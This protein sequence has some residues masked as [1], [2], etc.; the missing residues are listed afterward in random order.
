MSTS[1]VP[2]WHIKSCT[3]PSLSTPA[4]AHAY[5]S[6]DIERAFGIPGPTALEDSVDLIANAEA[7]LAA[8]ASMYDQL[9]TSVKQLAQQQE[10]LSR[11]ISN[12]KKYTLS[13][14]IRRLPT[15]ILSLIFSHAC[16]SFEPPDDH[17]TPLSISVTCFK[18]R[19]IAI[20]LPVLWTNIFVGPVHTDYWARERLAFY[21]DRAKNLPI[22]LKWIT[23][24][25]YG[26][27]EDNNN[28]YYGQRYAD[29]ELA[30]EHE[31][32]MTEV[33][34]T[35]ESWRTVDISLHLLDL[36]HLNENEYQ[37][38]HQLPFLEHIRCIPEN[39]DFAL[40]SCAHKL[41]TLCLHDEK[42]CVPYGEYFMSLS[43]LESITF[44]SG[45]AFTLF[46]RGFAKDRPGTMIFN[47]LLLTNTIPTK[48]WLACLVFRPDTFDYTII[49]ILSTLRLPVLEELTLED[50]QDRGHCDQYAQIFTGFQQ[51]SDSLVSLRVLKV[52]CSNMTRSSEDALIDE[53]DDQAQMVWTSFLAS[54][55]NIPTLQSLLIVES[56]TKPSLLVPSFISALSSPTVLPNLTSLELV[57]GQESLPVDPVVKLLELR[58]EKLSSVVLGVR[59][60]GEVQ[61]R[62]LD[63]MKILRMRGVQASLW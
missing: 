32:L 61:P 35:H 47:G 36:E 59:G 22:S 48:L 53:D 12:Q 5:P 28:D 41:R 13:S 38:Q 17:L 46:H 9:H 1:F 30:E 8:V 60:G 51:L 33:S 63:A 7:S 44:E 57:W 24:V 29:P 62:I 54:L 15:E 2:A 6:D 3:Y 4:F 16:Q 40:F 27:D 11:F 42:H 39:V 34:R 31:H 45:M 23:E 49:S 58:A 52:I 10:R 25:D 55:R 20:S 18:W 19:S 43:D 21:V 14:P 26:L 37:P 56:P 50:V